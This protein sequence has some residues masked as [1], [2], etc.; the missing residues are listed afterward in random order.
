MSGNETQDTPNGD[1]AAQAN[2]AADADIEAIVQPKAESPASAT[3]GAKDGERTVHD[4]IAALQAEAADF[5]DKWV[6]A[7]AEI[8]NVRK[9]LEKE[10]EDTAKYAITKFAR[11]L[12]NVGDNFQRAISAVPA[13]AAE[14]DAALKSL[15]EG[16]IM[17]ER[18][19]LNVFDRYGITRIDPAN[20]PFNPHMHQAVMETE[21]ADVA[22]GTVVQ[23]FQA[24]YMI[25][26][27]VLRPA[28]VVVSRGGPKAASPP[29]AAEAPPA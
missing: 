1:P 6:R 18:E 12:V 19:L 16:V 2:A 4:V 27:R 24:G 7:L 26:E 11:D 10:K 3:P 9:R 13:G 21:R 22:S 23:V 5:K 29:P 17:T 20:E 28:M 8:D 15:L 14:Q 25:E